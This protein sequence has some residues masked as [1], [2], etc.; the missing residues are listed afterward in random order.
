[1]NIEEKIVEIS[2]I[3]EELPYCQ[4][5][6]SLYKE[7]VAIR[8]TETN[9]KE[10]IYVAGSCFCLQ[11][12]EQIDL[13][14]NI[15]YNKKA[16]IMGSFMPVP[17]KC[18][19]VEASEEQPFLG[20][21]FILNQERL[22]KVLLKISL[23]IKIDKPKEENISVLF[24]GLATEEYVDVIYRIV[25]LLNKPEELEILGDSLLD[26]VYFRLLYNTEGELYKHLLYNKSQFKQVSKSIDYINA[27]LD[28]VITVEEL[29]ELVNMSISGYHKKFKDVMNMAPLQYVKSIKLDKAREFLIEGSNVSQ[30]AY[31]VG[32][33]SLAQFSREYKRYFGE[34]PS[35]T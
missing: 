35:K 10:E 6:K 16:K 26:E 22:A 29:A 7:L 30:A 11:G 25:K 21:A 2:K 20:I 19:I 3:L 28:K 14:G 5:T 4:G 17:V 23:S 12:K 15:S 18:S 32:Y 33:N 31:L 1:M 9:K 27:N 24:N 34:L 13:N 8:T